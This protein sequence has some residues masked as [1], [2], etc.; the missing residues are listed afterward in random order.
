[1][2]A[3]VPQPTQ[4]DIASW[5]TL[6]CPLPVGLTTTQYSISLGLASFD[7]TGLI[8]DCATAKSCQVNSELLN[9]DGWA[10][11]GTL[12]FPS[13]LGQPDL[14]FCLTSTNMC[15]FAYYGTDQVGNYRKWLYTIGL[16]SLTLGYKV[17]TTSQIRASTII[18][19]NYGFSSSAFGFSP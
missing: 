18:E 16:Q 4:K 15:T 12:T 1:M 13:V 19:S 6:T 14:G 7:L 8:S 11:A 9:Y 3:H 5:N 2:A 17:P 10:I